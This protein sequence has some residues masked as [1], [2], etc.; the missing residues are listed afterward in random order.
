MAT[1]SRDEVFKELEFILDV[2]MKIICQLGVT[3]LT[4]N[5]IMRLRM[6][7]VIELDKLAGEPLE[8]FLGD[9]MVSK[10]EVVVINDKYGIR[11]TDIIN[12]I[13]SGSRGGGG[14]SGSSKKDLL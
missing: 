14:D 5:D 10:G 4:L 2:P 6:G 7:S 11:L 12:P 9:K 8:V 13:E 3:E 1:P